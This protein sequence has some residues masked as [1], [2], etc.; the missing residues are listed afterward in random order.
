MAEKTNAKTARQRLSKIHLSAMLFPRRRLYEPEAVGA[1]F[2][3]AA[4]P[5]KQTGGPFPVRPRNHRS[6][7]QSC[8]RSDL[9]RLAPVPENIPAD[10]AQEEQARRNLPGLG[11][12]GG[13]CKS[14]LRHQHA[15]AKTPLVDHRVGPVCAR[16]QLGRT[17][18]NFDV[19]KIPGDFT[20]LGAAG[21]GWLHR[22]GVGDGAVDEKGK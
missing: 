12:G 3:G 22:V 10:S 16:V 11:D 20:D 21:D 19:L 5:I 1:H 9:R 13:G 14:G 8:S 17:G 6:I 7:K 18:E 2:C 4:A 15:R